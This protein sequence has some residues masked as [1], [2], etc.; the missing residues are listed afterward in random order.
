MSA[1]GIYNYLVNMG[2]PP[3]EARYYQSELG[4]GRSIVAVLR[5]G[6]P[7]VA[8]SILTRNGGSCRNEYIP[9]C[10][11][12]QEPPTE[13]VKAE[14][15]GANGRIDQSTDSGKST[16]I[17]EP[18]TEDVKAEPNSVDGRVAESTDHG[19]SIGIQ[20]PTKDELKCVTS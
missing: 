4:A 2:M 7:L 20:E 1:G 8:T 3:E 16:S 10:T 15:N 19:E 17:Q 14:P 6:A 5:T 11:D 9:Q 13:D 18:P 12:T